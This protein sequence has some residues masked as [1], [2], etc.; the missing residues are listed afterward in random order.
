MKAIVI[1]VT[2]LIA[3]IICSIV[4]ASFVNKKIEEMSTLATDVIEKPE[5]R[6]ANMETLLKEWTE[7]QKTF[8]LST[9]LRE[10]DRASE[11]LLSLSAAC[12]S[13]NEWAIR[14]SCALFCDA[15][16]DIARYETFNVFKIL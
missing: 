3:V 1:S 12:L 13:E 9:S 15:L 11:N 14:Q 6:H 7:N 8:R 4:N 10:L 5:S 2:L 16:D